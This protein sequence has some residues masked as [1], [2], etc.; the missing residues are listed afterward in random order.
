[1]ERI[2][3]YMK[4]LPNMIELTKSQLKFLK[5][6]RMCKSVHL[7]E[8]NQILLTSVISAEEYVDDH[9]VKKFLNTL[10]ESYV[11]DFRWAEMMKRDNDIKDITIKERS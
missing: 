6:V 7:T 4:H 5:W 9:A 8:H 1:M 10:R 3:R 2:Q 11:E